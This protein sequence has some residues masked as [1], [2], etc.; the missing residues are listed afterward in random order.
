MT[1][2]EKIRNYRK[3]AGLTQE[4]LADKLFVSRQAITKWE[5]DAG[6]P[7]INNIQALA[8]LFNI[9]VDALLKDEEMSLDVIREKIDLSQYQ[10]ESKLQT[11]YNVVVKDKFK[12]AVITQLFRQ[13]N[14]SFKENVFDFIVGSGILNTADRLSNNTADYLVER[15]NKKYLVTITK[16]FMETREVPL[17]TFTAKKTVLGNNI[18]TKAPKPLK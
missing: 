3:Q 16:E 6:T 17:H 10:R 13:K 5:S 4:Q 8:Q 14:L 18:Y 1:L 12:D 7:D 11:I 9:S 15:N 2:G